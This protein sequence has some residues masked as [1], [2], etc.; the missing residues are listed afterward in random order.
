MVRRSQQR[1]QLHLQQDAT[2]LGPPPGETTTAP[3]DRTMTP[4][5]VDTT[6]ALMTSTQ[7]DEQEH[8]VTF[9]EQVTSSEA[10]SPRAMDVRTHYSTSADQSHS[11]LA[12]PYPPTPT[13]TPVNTSGFE[14][15]MPT[16]V[17]FELFSRP[18]PRSN[19]LRHPIVYEIPSGESTQTVK[20]TA[21]ITVE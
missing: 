4:G 7:V 1:D 10:P 16:G 14:V 9:D 2:E 13:N 21:D 6:T 3:N 19:V 8:T 18:V 17:G 12:P 11:Y 15:S 5:D 20:E